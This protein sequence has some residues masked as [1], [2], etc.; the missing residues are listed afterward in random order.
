MIESAREQIAELVGARS[1]EI[2]FTGNATESNNTAIHA[3][4]KANPDK[5]HIIT[6]RVEHSSV[7]NH[8]LALE[9]DGHRVTY[10]P[11][12]RDGLLKPTNLE[13]ALTDDTAVVSLMWANSETDVLFPVREIGELSRSRGVLFHYDA[14][15]AVGKLP[16][17]VSA[18]SRDYLSLTGHKLGAPKGIGAL[19]VRRRVPF[20]P[21]LH[22]GHQERGRRGGTECVPLIVGL[23]KAAELALNKLPDYER[24]VRPLRVALEAG[25]LGSCS[26]GRGSAP[27]E[28]QSAT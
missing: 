25:I 3:A 13:N 16:V 4:L 22:G 5:R 18:L 7:L 21:L 8:C 28:M 27:F 26:S 1:S 20:S 12:D 10:L 2:V 14:V 23:G 9:S 15:Q 11:V 19:F 17:D 6:S 24:I